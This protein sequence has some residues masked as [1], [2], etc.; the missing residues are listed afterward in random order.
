MVNF[1]FEETEQ[2]VLC[3]CRVDAAIFFPKLCVYVLSSSYV[4]F[5]A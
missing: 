4:F 3:L 1:D 2:Q 5:K